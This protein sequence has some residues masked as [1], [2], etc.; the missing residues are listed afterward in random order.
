MQFRKK[1][2]GIFQALLYFNKTYWMELKHPTKKNFEQKSKE[3]SQGLLSIF[4]R[5]FLF[6]QI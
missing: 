4:D 5:Q 6:R 2:I 3:N 1:I